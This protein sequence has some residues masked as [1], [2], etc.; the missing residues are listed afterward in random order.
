M[1]GYTSTRGT[2]SY[3]LALVPVQIHAGNAATSDVISVNTGNP[4][5]FAPGYGLTTATMTPGANFRLE[6][7]GGVRK[8]DFLVVSKPGQANCGL[9][10]AVNLPLDAGAAVQCGGSNTTDSVEICAGV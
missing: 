9:L 4:L 3:N 1:L 6:N 5:D 2:T 7:R 8:W 10:N